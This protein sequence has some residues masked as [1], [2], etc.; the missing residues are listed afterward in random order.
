MCGP[1][2]T[3]I[4]HLNTLI[5]HTIIRSDTEYKCMKVNETIEIYVITEVLNSATL[6]SSTLTSNIMRLYRNWNFLYIAEMCENGR[7]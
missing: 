5:D 6:L 1:T 7:I 2:V 3:E 4:S